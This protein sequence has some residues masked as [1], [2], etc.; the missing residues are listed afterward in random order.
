M[1]VPIAAMTRGTPVCRHSARGRPP[2]L[3][4]S[5]DGCGNDPQAGH[6]DH[7]RQDVV[8]DRVDFAVAVDLDHLLRVARLPIQPK[9]WWRIPNGHIQL[10]Q[11]CPPIMVIAMITKP[12]TKLR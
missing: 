1:P 10:H 11:T 2:H 12:H 9:K 8:L 4:W 3:P 7:Y 5:I 6:R